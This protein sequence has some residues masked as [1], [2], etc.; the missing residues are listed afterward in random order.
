MP[1]VPNSRLEIKQYGNRLVA[2]VIRNG[3]NGERRFKYE[4]HIVSGQVILNFEEVKGEGYNVGSMVLYLKDSLKELVGKVTYFHHDQGEVVG[5]G[6][7][8]KKIV[9]A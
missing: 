8:Y 7:V 5:H 3:Q 2:T 1:T 9:A 6:R 4:G